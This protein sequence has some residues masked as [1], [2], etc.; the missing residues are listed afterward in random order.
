MILLRVLLTFGIQ[1]LQTSVSVL[2]NIQYQFIFLYTD[3]RLNRGDP[4]YRPNKRCML[5]VIMFIQHK[6]GTSK[7][8]II[9]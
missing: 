5:L 4:D 7:S 8:K 2:K 6:H 3:Q 9:N 1:Y